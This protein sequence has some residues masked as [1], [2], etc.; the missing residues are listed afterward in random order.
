MH[1][2]FAKQ[3]EEIADATQHCATQPCV[4]AQ[5]VAR[6]ARFSVAPMMDWT[7]VVKELQRL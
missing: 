1:A 4:T 3:N 6:A 5:D 7:D 2:P